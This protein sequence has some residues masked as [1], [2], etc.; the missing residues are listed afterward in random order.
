MDEVQLDVDLEGIPLQTDNNTYDR[1]LLER[2]KSYLES[3][4]GRMKATPG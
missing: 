2:Y 4:L 3:E 1:S